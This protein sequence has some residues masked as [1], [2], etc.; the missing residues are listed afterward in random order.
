MSTQTP[1]K[2]FSFKAPRDWDERIDHALKALRDVPSLDG[3]DGALILHELELAIL[4]NPERLTRAATQSD[5]IRAVVGLLLSAT[6]KVERD[7]TLGEAYAEAAA[8]RAG[9]E[10]AFTRAAT[11]AAARRSRDL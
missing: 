8:E 9:D 7:R 5:L 4:R 3:P 1:T 2:T 10:T 11:R 6:E